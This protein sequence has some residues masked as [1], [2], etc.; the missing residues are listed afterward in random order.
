M[1][2]INRYF[3]LAFVAFALVFTASTFFSSY[4]FSWLVKLLP[5]AILLVIAAKHLTGNLGKVFIAGIAFSAL[6]DFFLDYDR[7]NWF[8]FGLASFFIAHVC[9]I[10]SLK[11]QLSKLSLRRNIV[12]A[13]C[14]FI[15]SGIIFSLFSAELKELFVPVFFY[16][17]ILVLMAISTVLTARSNYWLML[18]GLSFVASDTMIGLDKFYSPLNF[19]HS[20]IMLTYYFAQF[21]LLI[22]IIQSLENKPSS[23]AESD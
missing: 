17:L 2:S 3:L 19:H 23:Q 9:Y 6:G 20:A 1:V 8:I 13:S 10:I 7:V 4:P 21:S 22:G 18:G 12:L 5:M 14:Y 11:P 15:G 16:M